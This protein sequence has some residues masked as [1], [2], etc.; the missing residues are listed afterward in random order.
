[1]IWSFGSFLLLLGSGLPIVFAL[2]VAATLTLALTTSTPLTIVA[3][4]VYAGLDS[5][6]LMAIPFFVLAGLIMEAGGIARRFVDLA[7]ALV[8][9]ITGALFGVAVVTGTGLAAISGSGSADTAAISSMLVPEMRKRGY[10]VDFA[11]ALIAASG[12]LAPVIPPSVMMVV[13]A[14]VANLSVGRM[15]LGGVL[16]GLAIAL[17]LLA[18]GYLVARRGGPAYRDAEPFSLRR[19]GRA[20]VAALPGL[21]MPV[22]IVGGI[23]G[24]VFTPTE[25]AAVAVFA[26]LAI[27]LGVYRELRPRDLY[28]LLLRAAG[29]SAAV[30]MI[31][32]T[33]S[34]FSW[35]I[36]SQNVPALLGGW[37]RGVSES[38]WAFLLLVNLLLF[39]VGMFMESISAILILV[40][41]LMPIATGYGIDPI[42]FGVVA[43]L[44]LSL[45]LIT[46][47]YGICLYVAAT[48][49]GRSVGEV[50]RR[51]WI[52]LLPFAAVLLLTTYIPAV[53]LW[54]PGL[55]MD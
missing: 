44:N 30:M 5:F 42:H 2:G 17:G 47:P 31:I 33:A 19:L 39:V 37:L 11:A 51:V 12:A 32:A 55:L 34:I 48:V 54:L 28:D 23:I 45:G 7:T 25:A 22:I 53:V 10:D 36:A 3:Q 14:T 38:P 13:L 18:A 41:M 16:P 27:A 1:M 40:P 9:W 35:L 8:G 46:P 29:I 52:P 49:A 20:T 26:G 21:V 43:V 24:G 6:P 4:R 50:A 15:F